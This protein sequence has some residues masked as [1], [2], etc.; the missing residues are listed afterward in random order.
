[1][2]FS[3]ESVALASIA[4]H[5]ESISPP[6]SGGVFTAGRQGRGW[7]VNEKQEILYIYVK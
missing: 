4:D 3:S 7:S 5:G 6:E 2:S 1:M